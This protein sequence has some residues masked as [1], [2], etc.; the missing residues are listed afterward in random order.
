MDKA[1]E[2]SLPPLTYG[3]SCDWALISIASITGCEVLHGHLD[4][5]DIVSHIL[6][7]N[8]VDLLWTRV[9]RLVILT[10]SMC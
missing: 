6:E 1:H 4:V 9:Y 3:R 8:S 7:C 2:C 10:E 5:A